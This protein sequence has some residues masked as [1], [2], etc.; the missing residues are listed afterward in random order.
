MIEAPSRYDSKSREFSSG[1]I[2]GFKSIFRSEV[3]HRGLKSIGSEGGS[4]KEMSLQQGVVRYKHRWVSHAPR[5]VWY[6]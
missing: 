6:K 5:R 3:L 4:S 2:S 1:T